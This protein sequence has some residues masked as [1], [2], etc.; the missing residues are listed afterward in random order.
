MSGTNDPDMNA[1]RGCVRKKYNIYHYKQWDA[2][3]AG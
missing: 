2:W 3:K 1:E